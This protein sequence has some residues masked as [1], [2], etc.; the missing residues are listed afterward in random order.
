[1]IILFGLAGSG[2]STQGQILAKKRGMEWLS[3]GQVLRN[4]GEFDS[5]LKAGKLVDDD[6]VI[7]L[8]NEEIRRIRGEGREIILDGFPRDEYQAEWVAKNVANDISRAV[9][10]EVPKEEL[11]RRIEERGRADDTKEAIE[12]R[13]KIVE[14]NI[15]KI[16]EILRG[17]G[18]EIRRISGVGEIPE[19]T[20]RLEEAVFEEKQEEE[21]N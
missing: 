7:E 6:K 20:A 1:M 2:K 4:T 3:V 8:M 5:T 17:A 13:F 21:Y 18:V 15:E 12:R 14:E 10:I 19:I 9:F 16:L 11:W